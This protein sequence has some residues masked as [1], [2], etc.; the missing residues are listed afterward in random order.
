MAQ[1]I[2]EIDYS[3]SLADIRKQFE[4]ALVEIQAALKSFLLTDAKR[5][6]LLEAERAINDIL[7]D[8][9]QGIDKW[10]DETGSSVVEE[11]IVAT[12]LLLGL[13]A[14]A[15]SFT[16]TTE[17]ESIV[18]YT[19]EALKTDLKSVTTNLQRQSRTV[20]RRAYTDSIKQTTRQS[21]PVRQLL[22]DADVAIIDKAGRRWRTSHYIDMLTRTLLA[23]AEREAAAVT[24]LSDGNGHAY[25]SYN[26][27]TT[28]ACKDYQY[29]LVKLAPDINS[30]YPYYRDLPHIFHPCCRHRLIPIS[31]FD[32]LPTQ[33]RRKNNL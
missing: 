7:S 29:S 19:V 28:D 1:A 17:Q 16:L 25:I 24:G 11:S 33:V 27:S 14:L 23:E 10:A 20:L 30:P 3:Q 26:S 6:D 31:S 5:Q 13:V 22:N 8:L 32:N 4:D 12:L 18:E 15:E 2:P 9:E 21:Q